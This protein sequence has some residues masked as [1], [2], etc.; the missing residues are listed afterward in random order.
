MLLSLLRCLDSPFVSNS[1]NGDAVFSRSLYTFAL[2]NKVVLSYLSRC[3]PP[4]GARAFYTY[5]QLR[6]ERLLGLMCRVCSTLEER[7][8]RY[9]VFKTL[10][11]FDEDVADIDIIHLSNDR[12]EY[13]ELVKA[14]QDA[15]YIVKERGFYSTTLMDSRYR[16]VTDL[17]VDIYKDVSVGPLVY[18]DK[19]LFSNH[20]VERVVGGCRVKT[21]NPEAELLATIAHSL[22]KER[23]VKLLDYLTTLHLLHKMDNDSMASFVD[24]VRRASLVY[25][26][27]LFL[28]IAAYLHRSAYGF[29]PNEVIELLKSLGGAMNVCSVVMIEEPPYRLG[30]PLLARIYMEKLKDPLFRVSLVKGLGWFSSRRSRARLARALISSH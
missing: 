12:E 11:P 8:F 21:L 3:K 24:L 13:W 22:I 19:R 5:H 9:A 20:V 23:E 16:Y 25:G 10:K 6:Y 17:M 14:L 7:D 28:S 2:H 1:Y 27:R 29:I 26:A 18:L 15:G 4:S 30:L